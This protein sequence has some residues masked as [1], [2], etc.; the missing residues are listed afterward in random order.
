L[1]VYSARSRSNSFAS[2]I[3]DI[4]VV[5]NTIV[6]TSQQKKGCCITLRGAGSGRA[7]MQQTH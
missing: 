3:N 7:E 1:T 4:F 6:F 5:Y 2:E